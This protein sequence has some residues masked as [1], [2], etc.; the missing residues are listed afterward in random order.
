[1]LFPSTELTFWNQVFTFRASLKS[2]LNS[3]IFGGGGGG[4]KGNGG[5]GHGGNDE[6][7]DEGSSRPFSLLAL[8]SL[9]SNIETQNLISQI[10]ESV[11]EEK[12]EME[13]EEKEEVEAVFVKPAPKPKPE[14]INWGK[15]SSIVLL[16]L[17]VS[18]GFFFWRRSKTQSPPNLAEDTLVQQTREIEISP[19]AS[20]QQTSDQ[21][22]V[23]VQDLER[24]DQFFTQ[25]STESAIPTELLKPTE[26]D[27]AEQ[28]S[29]VLEKRTDSIVEV[30]LPVGEPQ[31]LGEG[32][33]FA[34]SAEATTEQ[35]YS[36]LNAKDSFF[37]TSPKAE[38]NKGDIVTIKSMI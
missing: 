19:E 18:G 27:V 4:W 36:D 34:K 30:E 6:D 31:N 2:T 28:L 20:N 13:E 5:G 9:A 12:E 26:S 23:F 25:D 15:V 32:L 22:A 8:F 35:Y 37:D 3:S 33:E 10:A 1:M 17:L 14:S 11:E 24:K 38:V 21:D 16:M 29:E 7:F